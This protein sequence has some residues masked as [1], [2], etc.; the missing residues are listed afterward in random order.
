[1]DKQEL[2]ELVRL[3]QQGDREAFG[4]LVEAYQRAV[5]AIAERRLGNYAEAQELT[6]EVFVQAL[7]K[8]AQLETPECFGGWLRSIA[9]RMSINRATRR[10][11]TVATEPETMEAN[12]VERETPF[13]QALANERQAQL[14]AGLARL[15]TLDRQTLTAFYIEGHSIDEMSAQFASPV[16][17]IKR[18]LHIARKRLAEELAGAMAV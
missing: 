2:I 1:M 10:G 16:G 18:R 15:K 4:R 3:A 17:T 12:C 6:Q 8:I 14:R 13:D 7:R 9:V 11:L 5:L